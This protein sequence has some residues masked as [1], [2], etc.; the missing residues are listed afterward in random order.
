MVGTVLPLL[1]ADVGGVDPS[2][3][4]LETLAKV[5]GAM[6]SVRLDVPYGPRPNQPDNIC[7]MDYYQWYDAP[8]RGRML[9]AYVA[10]GYRHAPTGP[11]VDADGYHGQYPTAPND[12]TQDTWD[13]WLDAMQEW[14]NVGVAPIFF[15]KPDNWSFDRLKAVFE[16]FLLQPRS[17]R[18]IRIVVGQG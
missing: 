15:L 11:L 5:R 7:A 2:T 3:M 4:P 12:P 8:T 1:L 14:W 10:R 6:W 9:G 18:L 17:Q 16:P 13:A